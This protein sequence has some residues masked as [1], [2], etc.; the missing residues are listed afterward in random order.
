MISTQINS[1]GLVLDIFGALL[2]IKYGIPPKIDR[3]GNIYFIAEGVD[4]AEIQKARNY[5][6]WSTFAI[7][8]IV[9]GFAL[10]LLSNYIYC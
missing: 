10:Q 1:I 4:E 3:E 7:L 2:L 5:D 6:R 9:L 8:L